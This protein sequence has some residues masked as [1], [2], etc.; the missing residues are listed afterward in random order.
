MNF[1]G[2]SFPHPVLGLGDD[3]EGEAS[4]IKFTNDESSDSEN[5][6][7]TIEYKLENPDLLKLLTD[8]K[9]Y[10]VCEIS[11]T[12]TLY[13][14][15]EK[16][17]SFTHLISVPKNFVRDR[18]E[19]LFLIVSAEVILS[20]SNSKV[21][22]DFTGYKFEID[23]GDVL[24]YIGES[25][26]IA[27][28]SYQKLKA[29]SS[30]MEI[31]KGE[32]EKGDFNIILESPKIEVQLSK[33]DYDKYC[34]S[35]IGKSTSFA[36][37]FHSAIVLPTLI[38]ALYQLKNA[39]DDVTDYSWA[40]IIKFRLDDDV[41]L[42]FIPFEEKNIP[43]IAQQILGMPVERLL[44]DLFSRVTSNSDNENENQ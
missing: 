5:Y 11:C 7:L 26:F 4:V 8:K 2:Y 33:S 25:S 42:K 44:E 41:N 34:D 23:S 35:R 15:S 38:H 31:I 32:N 29:V 21:H 16:S 10:F 9:A 3:I 39:E 24:A 17:N 22:D 43:K 12:G 14:K 18:V 40:K 28:I 20:Y 13:R 36:S 27:G 1:N 6:L 19:L 30:F 37:I